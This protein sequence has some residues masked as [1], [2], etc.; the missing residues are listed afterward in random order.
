MAQLFNKIGQLGLGIALAGGV[1]NSAL[2]N[3]KRVALSDLYPIAWHR[4]VLILSQFPQWMVA[5]AQLYSIVFKVLNRSSSARVHISLFHGYNDRLYL[6]FDRSHEMFRWWRAAKIY[7]M[8]ISHCVYYSARN[9]TNCHVSTQF[10]ALTMMNV[11][12]H[13]LQ[14]KCWKPLSP[15]SMPAKWSHSVR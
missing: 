9:R 5:I 10:W 12:C 13:R 7:K 1:I 4:C 3:G 2:Y 8:L 11:C 14:R 15:S 6:T